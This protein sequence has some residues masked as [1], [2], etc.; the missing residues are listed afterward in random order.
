MN[1]SILRRDHAYA[2]GHP[3]LVLD[4]NDTDPVLVGEDPVSSRPCAPTLRI[5]AIDARRPRAARTPAL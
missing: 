4:V 5:A 3:I 2:T 1:M